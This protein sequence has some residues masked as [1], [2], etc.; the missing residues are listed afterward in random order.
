MLKRTFTKVLS[1]P[2]ELNVDGIGDN[3]HYNERDVVT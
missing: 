2:G 3:Q 1:R